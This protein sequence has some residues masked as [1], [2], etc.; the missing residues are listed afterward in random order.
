M[1]SHLVPTAAEAEMREYMEKYDCL[2][3][4]QL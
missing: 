1:S 3:A 2:D 4:Q